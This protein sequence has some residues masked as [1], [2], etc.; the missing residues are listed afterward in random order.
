MTLREWAILGPLTA[1]AIGM[2]V[3]P[4]VFLKPMEPA[5]Q[6]IVDR[7]QAR[8]PLQ[9]DAVLPKGLKPKPRDPRLPGIQPAGRKPEAPGPLA[10]VSFEEARR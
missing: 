6:Q 9:V 1:A 2:G 4:N 5:V 8:Q 7:V 10:R 3:F